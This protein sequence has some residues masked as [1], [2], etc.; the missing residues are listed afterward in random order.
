MKALLASCLLLIAAPFGVAYAQC[1][2]DVQCGLGQG[3][4]YGVC[5]DLSC[6]AITYPTDVC[7]DPN[8]VPGSSCE[9][10]L[11]KG[12]CLKAVCDQ[13]CDK[14]CSLEVT[15][16]RDWPCFWEDGAEQS[17]PEMF[18]SCVPKPCCGNYICDRGEDTFADKINFLQILRI[19]KA[20]IFNLY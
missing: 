15:M 14:E 8:A 18:W 16:G 4:E 7:A 1:T 9:I 19:N 3:C 11:A 6:A 2:S 20:Y 10:I 13:F 5:V 17:L 12:E